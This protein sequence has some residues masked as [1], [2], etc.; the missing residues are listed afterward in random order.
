M[1]MNADHRVVLASDEWRTYLESEALPFAF[2]DVTMAD[3][4][5]DVL[6]IGPGPGLTTDL[7]RTEVERLTSI[8]LDPEL[9]AALTARLA[10][11]NVDV[12]EADATGMPLPDDRF[13][14][15]VSFTM[16]HHVPTTSLQDQLLAEAR[17]VLRPGA[18]FVASDSLASDGLE[19]FHE[20]D[21]Y[22]P[23]DPDGLA[24]R[25]TAIGFTDVTVRT[26]ADSWAA[27]AR[28]LV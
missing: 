9:A 25:L 21:V 5:A 2:D 16:L 12:I 10:G 11:A 28:V 13:T 14:G 7:L 6:E 17:R 1:N 15:A 24:D 8:E 4:G 27:H 22:N 19:A 3:L 26:N 23:I 20:G 18:L